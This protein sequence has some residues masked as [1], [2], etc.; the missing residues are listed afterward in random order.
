MLASAEYTA[1]D[2]WYG[3]FAAQ[4][5]AGTNAAAAY[6]SGP[7]NPPGSVA[8]SSSALAQAIVQQHCTAALG[9][10]LLYLAL[11]HDPY[12]PTE[13]CPT[14]KCFVLSLLQEPSES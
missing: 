13:Q 5:L 8:S 10:G 3:L 12:F 6:D 11:H 1:D 4:L 9:G 14:G 2:A 7:S